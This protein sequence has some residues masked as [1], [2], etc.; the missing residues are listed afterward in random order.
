[1]SNCVLF[2]SLERWGENVS[3]LNHVVYLGK[4]GKQIVSKLLKAQ[5]K[6]K[7]SRRNNGH[8]DS[9]F[10]TAQKVNLLSL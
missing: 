5:L 10:R 2:V 7:L 8:N 9:S 1:M 4:Q 3:F 6:Q